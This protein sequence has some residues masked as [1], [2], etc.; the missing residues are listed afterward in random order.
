MA[1]L[2]FEVQTD[3]DSYFSYLTDDFLDMHLDDIMAQCMAPMIGFSTLRAIG[4]ALTV[5]LLHHQMLHR[6]LRRCRHFHAE[7]VN[8][9]GHLERMDAETKRVCDMD[10]RARCRW[11]ASAT[12]A[13]AASWCL[14]A[15][16]AEQGDA[17][18]AQAGRAARHQGG[19]HRGRPALHDG[20]QAR[21]WSSTAPWSIMR[22]RMQIV[23]EALWRHHRLPALQVHFCSSALERKRAELCALAARAR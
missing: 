18:A 19:V 9:A 23:A 3:I 1:I 16:R 5:Q 22:A 6:Q 8:A 11:A 4:N 20:A 12:T 14:A 13:T 15:G 10:L 2:A 7:D 21:P 17:V